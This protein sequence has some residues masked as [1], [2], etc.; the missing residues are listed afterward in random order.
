M[1]SNFTENIKS[2][3]LFYPV[4]DNRQMNILKRKTK[5]YYLYEMRAS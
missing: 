4:R 5:N 2:N 3:L 1:N